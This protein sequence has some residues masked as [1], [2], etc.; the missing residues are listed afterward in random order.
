MGYLVSLQALESIKEGD[1]VIA[2]LIFSQLCLWYFSRAI[3]MTS[4]II[5]KA[6]TVYKG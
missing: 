6:A 4:S 1:C 5:P 2:G 3:I